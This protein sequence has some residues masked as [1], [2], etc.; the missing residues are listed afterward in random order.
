VKEWLDDYQI[1]EE[2]RS[3]YIRINPDDVRTYAR[4]TH[5][6]RPFLLKSVDDD[7]AE[8]FVPPLYLLAVG[9]CLLQQAPERSWL[10]SRLVAFLEFA[11]I[12]FPAAASVGDLIY[13]T[14]R[15]ENITERGSRGTLFYHHETR[16][17]HDEVLV[18]TG[19]SMLVERKPEE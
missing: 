13:S 12:Q 19:Y 10:P 3:P 7:A 14:A 17:Q 15:V 2:I 6:M 9:M 5:D 16:N 1:G 18:S 4:Y 8:K 11:G